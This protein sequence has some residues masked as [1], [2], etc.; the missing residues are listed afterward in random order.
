MLE[1]FTAGLQTALQ[2]SVE[3]AITTVLQAQRERREAPREQQQQAY[4]VQAASDDEDLAENIFAA[5]GHN[6]RDRH[7]NYQEDRREG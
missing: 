5:Q 6:Q 7:N 2:T 3:N 1:T 4:N